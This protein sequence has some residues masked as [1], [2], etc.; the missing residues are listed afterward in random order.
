MQNFSVG[1]N[2]KGTQ[3]DVDVDLGQGVVLDLFFDDTSSVNDWIY[4]LES[5]AGSGD[6]YEVAQKFLAAA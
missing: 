2:L 6:I 5:P 3:P 4:V 1:Q